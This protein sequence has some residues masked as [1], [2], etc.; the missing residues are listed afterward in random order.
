MIRQIDEFPS[1]FTPDDEQPTII[2]CGANI[3]ISVLEWKTRWPGSQ[4]VCFEPDP[5]AFA[6]LK[7]NIERNDVPGVQTINAAVSDQ[8]GESLFFGD[9]SPGGDSRGNSIDPAWGDREMSSSVSVDCY[10]LSRYIE[11]NSI[12]FLKLDIEGAEQRVLFEIQEQLPLVDAIYVEVH[13]TQK[14]TRYNSG[15]AIADLLQSTGFKIEIESRP[16]EH[17]LPPHLDQWQAETKA[18][19]SHILAWRS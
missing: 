4:I 14:S 16:S 15:R 6:T 10:K 8:E 3:G 1:F 11:G 5:R 7:K 12:A 19:Q 9:F 18:Q 13:E 17:A 2:D